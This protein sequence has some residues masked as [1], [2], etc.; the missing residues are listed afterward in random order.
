MHLDR[1]PECHVDGL[2]MGHLSANMRRPIGS[3]LD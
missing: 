3:E 2:P 1:L